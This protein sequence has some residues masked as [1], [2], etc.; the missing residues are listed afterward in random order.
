MVDS[1]IWEM[2]AEL[3]YYLLCI[4]DDCPI[5]GHDSVHSNLNWRFHNIASI[6]SDDLRFLGV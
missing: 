3:N 5:Y 6:V 4:A 1:L 2:L